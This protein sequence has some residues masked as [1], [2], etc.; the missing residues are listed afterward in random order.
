MNQASPSV[1][2]EVPRQV[3]GRQQGL[4]LGLEDHA[5]DVAT[6]PAINCNLFDAYS[7]I[8]KDQLHRVTAPVET[9][10]PLD[11]PTDFALSHL[12]RLL[13]AASPILQIPRTQ[14]KSGLT[15]LANIT[16]P[17]DLRTQINSATKDSTNG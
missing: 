12:F 5:R 3:M 11:M 13:C 8:Q 7:L 2:D 16:P 1:S 6:R 15:T 17:R 14:T 10:S 9:K 4:V